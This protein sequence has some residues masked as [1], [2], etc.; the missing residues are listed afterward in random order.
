MENRNVFALVAAVFRPQS[1]LTKL[2][3]LS[4]LTLGL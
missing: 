2:L 4:M 3:G 1:S